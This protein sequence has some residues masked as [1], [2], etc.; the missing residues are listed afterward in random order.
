MAIFS[1]VEAYN[2]HLFCGEKIH[3]TF[4]FALFFVKHKTYLMPLQSEKG[5]HNS[6]SISLLQFFVCFLFPA[7]SIQ[8]MYSEVSNRR[9][10]IINR[11]CCV[12]RERESR[13][14][15]WRFQGK[16][17]SNFSS[18]IRYAHTKKRS[19]RASMLVY[20]TNADEK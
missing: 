17:F 20:K 2:T 15:M 6:F 8:I 5:V 12:E 7:F 9:L 3:K 4:W 1:S 14:F 13:I 16:E 18:R 10:H 11:W 19:H